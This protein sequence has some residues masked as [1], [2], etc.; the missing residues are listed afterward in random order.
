MQHG[1]NSSVTLSL[2]KDRLIGPCPPIYS[3]FVLLFRCYCVIVLLC[4]NRICI[5][6]NSLT[7]FGIKP[8]QNIMWENN[9]RKY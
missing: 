7:V 2:Y 6:L 1:T 4:Y 3:V 8:R 5:V 9:R